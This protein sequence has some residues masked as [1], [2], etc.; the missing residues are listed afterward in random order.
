M[1]SIVSMN[2]YLAEYPHRYKPNRATKSW[3]AHSAEF[4]SFVRKSYDPISLIT[5]FVQ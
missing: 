4:G 3:A 2:W 5:E 1:C